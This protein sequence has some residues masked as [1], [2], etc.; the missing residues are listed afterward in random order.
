MPHQI[1]DEAYFLKKEDWTSCCE[2]NL[3]P[4]EAERVFFVIVRVLV[5]R[6]MGLLL[7]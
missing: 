4:A 3:I 5:K 2:I 1:I 7:L 6:E